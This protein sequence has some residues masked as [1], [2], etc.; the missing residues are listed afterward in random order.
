MKAKLTENPVVAVVVIALLAA[1]T[2]LVAGYAEK[3]DTEVQVAG[4]AKCAACPLQGGESC[5]KADE[6]CC[7]TG[8]PCASLCEKDTC[9]GKASGCSG[10]KANMASCPASP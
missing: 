9:A 8:V 10:P 4:D 1:G 6:R 3:P 2:L 5:C 7:E